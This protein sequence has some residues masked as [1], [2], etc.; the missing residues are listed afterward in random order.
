MSNIMENENLA[1]ET[2][3]FLL[4]FPGY[5]IQILDDKAAK[6]AE[7]KREALR[8]LIKSAPPSQFTIREL[9]NKNQRGA[10]IFFSPNKFTKI[11]KIELCEGVNAWFMEIDDLSKEEQLQRISNSPLKPSA[12]VESGNSLHCYWFAEDGTIENFEKIIKGLIQFFASDSSCSDISRVFRIP[13]FYHNKK[14]PFTVSIKLKSYETKYTEDE[15]MKAFPFHKREYKEN[16]RSFEPIT[17]GMGFWEAVSKLD[18]KTILNRLSGTYMVN[19]EVITF[20]SRSGNSEY[21]DVNGSPADAWLDE[22]GMIG[23]GKGGGPTFIQWLEYYGW[24]K[25]DVAKWIKKNCDDLLKPSVQGQKKTKPDAKE[26]TEQSFWPIPISQLMQKKFEDLEWV[27]EKLLPGSGTIIISGQPGSYK[28]WL[29]LDLVLAVASGNDAFGFLATSQAGVLIV[30]EENGPRLLQ[31]RFKKL[32]FNQGLPIY[33]LSLV[34]FR[35]S[36]GS[37]KTLVSFCKSKKIKL[38]VFDS[39]IRIHS[40]EENSATDMSEVFDHLKEFRR[41]GIAVLLLHHN[42]KPGFGNSN[43]SFEMRGSSDILAAID[44]H[45]GI[46]KKDGYVE[47]K[48]TKLRQEPEI[49]PF[50]L[51][52]I[53]EDDVF[54]FEYAGEIGEVQNKKE[55]AKNAIKDV[56]EEAKRP[57]YKTELYDQIKASGFRAGQSTIKEALNEMEKSDEVFTQQG[58][59]NKTFCSLEPFNKQA[60]L[61]VG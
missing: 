10:G 44:S 22:Q 13:G 29:A 24:S 48:Q 2:K 46:N 31:D 26:E 56:L 25:G 54:R 49:P 41:N 61:Q 9:V 20:R 8:E 52:I 51:K 21:I 59:G 58:E 12:I 60:F 34:G 11:R 33:V 53:S 4:N 40:G 17:E 18:N 6:G 27:V 35:L 55:D 15:M 19:N 50:K 42:R 47:I 57:M 7:P 30:D 39:L 5:H 28:T 37:V 36:E 14:D 32:K 23:S 3:A 16:T 1:E 38:V 45:I 43:P